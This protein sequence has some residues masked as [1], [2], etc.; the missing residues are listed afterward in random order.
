MAIPAIP[1]GFT[2]QTGN[3]T[4][5]SSWNQSAGAT[6]YIV[7]RSTDQLTYT[8]VATVTAFQYLDTA[9]TQG[10]A[11]YYQV[12]ASNGS[13]TSA[14]TTPQGVVPTTTGEMSLGAIRLAAQQRADRVNS[15]FVGLAEWNFF[16]NQ[17]MFELYD[18]LITTYEDYF[19]APAAFLALNGQD[20]I[21]NLPDG[22]R[23]FQDAKGNNFVPAPFYKLYGVDLNINT[24]NNAFVTVTKFNFISRNSYVYPN[25]SSAIYGVFNLQYRLIGTNQIE[26]IPTPSSANQQIR[27]WYFPRMTQLLLD[28]DVTTSGISGWLQYVIIRAAKYALDKEE[29]DTTKL[30]AEL[31]FLKSRIEE[32]A[33]NR[34]V[35]QADTISDVRN[36]RGWGGNGGGWNSPV[37][38]W[39]VLAASLGTML[40]HAGAAW[41]T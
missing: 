38:G 10:T 36:V 17:A 18:L 7:Q 28:T 31:L 37:G 40:L 6:S 29:S 26:F 24:A 15:E 41:L 32:S 21:Y 13:G 33:M 35:G 23:T 34:D 12:A 9:V 20:F 19:V 25:S 8:T 5:L 16:I 3:G 14:Y 39:I 22:V 27:L 30:D 2:V 1:S 11:Y 4:N